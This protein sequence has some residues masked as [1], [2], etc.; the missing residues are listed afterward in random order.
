MKSM[1]KF[2]AVT[3]VTVMAVASFAQGGGGGG[4]GQG[5]GGF[6]GMQDPSGAFLVNREDVQGEIKLTDDQK[7]KLQA[8]RQAQMEK[9]REAFQ[10][11]QSMSQEERATAMQKMQAE[12]NKATLG[13]LTDDQKKRLKELAI[14]RM[15]NAAITH[16]EVQKELGMTADQTA[17]IKEL[18]D[19]QTAANTVLREKMMNQEIEREQF[20]ESSRKNTEV[21]NT[22]LGKIITADQKAKLTT[23][24][25]KAFKFVEQQRGG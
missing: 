24:G 8:A 2:I 22:E 10:N 25:G 4:R 3:A 6:G 12:N 23:M 18:Q 14:Q 11:F 21:M 1:M 20:M 15:G 17:K 19:K 9:G 16:A 7:S 5:R 13:V